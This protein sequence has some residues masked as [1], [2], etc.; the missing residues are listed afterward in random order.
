MSRSVV[1]SGEVLLDFF[2]SEAD[3]L[4]ADLQVGWNCHQDNA[5]IKSSGSTEIG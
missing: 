5:V 2:I 4:H 1:S 3:S